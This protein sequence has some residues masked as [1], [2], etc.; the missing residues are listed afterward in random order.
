VLLLLQLLMVPTRCR[1][2]HMAVV[3]DMV[4]L[5]MDMVVVLMHMAVDMV[6][7]SLS[8]ESMGNLASME[9]ME[10]SRSGSDLCS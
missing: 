10:S 7:E 9:D 1:R 3:M 8:T 2:I 5:L 4:E 6:M